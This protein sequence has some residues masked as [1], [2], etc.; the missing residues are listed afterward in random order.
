MT[1]ETYSADDLTAKP[2]KTSIT[3]ISNRTAGKLVLT[4]KKAK[5]ADG[6][7]IYRRAGTT[8][9]YVRAAVIKSGSTT[10]YTNAKLKKGHTYYY[11]IRSYRYDENGRKIYSGWS[12]VKKQKV[13]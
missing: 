4:W 7:E 12:T 2:A 13:K 6:Y 8:N 1:Q 10:K 5:S 11:R 3:G 9:P